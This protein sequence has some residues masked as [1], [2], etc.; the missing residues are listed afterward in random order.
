MVVVRE[1]G[2]IHDLRRQQGLT[3]GDRFLGR[4]SA[5]A[6]PTIKLRFSAK[7]FLISNHDLHS[8]R[9]SAAVRTVVVR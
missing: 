9:R 8:I 2:N 6:F 1:L 4:H 7:L 5:Q 3:E